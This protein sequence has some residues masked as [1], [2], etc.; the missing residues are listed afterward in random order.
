MY[1]VYKYF[2]IIFEI[3]LSFKA[4]KMCTNLT[5]IVKNCKHTVYLSNRV[6]KPQRQSKVLFFFYLFAKLDSQIEVDLAL[7]QNESIKTK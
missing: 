7:K 3:L 2:R 1:L 4:F 6:V 5:S